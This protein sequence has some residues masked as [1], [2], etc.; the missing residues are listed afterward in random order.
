MREGERER[1]AG[2]IGTSF[3]TSNRIEFN[4]N[5]HETKTNPIEMEMEIRIMKANAVQQ[6]PPLPPPLSHSLSL[7]GHTPRDT[8]K[9]PGTEQGSSGSLPLPCCSSCSLCASPAP[10][11]SPA[12]PVSLAPSSSC[13]FSSSF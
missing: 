3:I 5:E 12:F 11:P 8:I 2:G 9:W 7:C 13:C 6:Q 4:R 1:G 10:A